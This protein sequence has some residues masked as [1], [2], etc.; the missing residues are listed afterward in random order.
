MFKL[1]LF[2]IRYDNVQSM[3]SNT[4]NPHV[5]CMPYLPCTFYKTDTAFYFLF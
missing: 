4:C 1:N 3:G 2:I 5:Y